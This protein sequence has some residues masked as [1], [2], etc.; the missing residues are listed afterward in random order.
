MNNLSNREY[1]DEL[2]KHFWLNGYMTVR[3]KYGTYLPEPT[4]VGKY[5]VDAVGRFNKKFAIGIVVSEDDLNDK[6]FILKLEFLATRHT[7]FSNKR[8]I[9]FIGIHP[10]LFNK[11]KLLVESLS[12]EAAKNIKIVLLNDKTSSTVSN[13]VNKKE[14]NFR[15]FS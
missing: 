13:N 7:K 9:L 6:K 4:P 15:N 10:E 12:A 1:I 2:I 8:V 11:L 3:R 5:D 14:F